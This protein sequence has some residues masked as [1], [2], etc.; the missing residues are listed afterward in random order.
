MKTEKEIVDML[1]Q[2]ADCAGNEENPCPFFDE[3]DC[4][5]AACRKQWENWLRK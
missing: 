5:E 2:V 3:C 1:V 4:N